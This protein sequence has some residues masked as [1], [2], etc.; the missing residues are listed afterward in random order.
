[1]NTE[2]KTISLFTGAMGLDLGLEQAGINILLGQDFEPSCI[3][4]MAANGYK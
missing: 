3:K 1:M 4:T 2:Y